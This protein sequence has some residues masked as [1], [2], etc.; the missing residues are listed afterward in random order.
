MKKVFIIFFSFL[1]LAN[2]YSQTKPIQK[3]NNKPVQKGYQH[4]SSPINVMG[5]TNQ[6]TLIELTN[7]LD[8]WGFV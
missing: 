7:Q 4:A 2:I 3:N 1:F 6:T 8:E 5:F